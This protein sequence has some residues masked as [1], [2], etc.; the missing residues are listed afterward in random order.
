MTAR[1]WGLLI[2]L[3]FLWGGA[4]FFA[5]VALKEV[6]HHGL[7]FF[8]VVIAAIALGL[9]AM[10][11][12]LPFP[13]DW[14]FWRWVAVLAIFSTATPFTLLYWAQTHIASGL[15]AVLNAMTPIF[16]LLVAHFFT[17]DEKIDGQRFAGVL[18]GVGGV[19]TIVGPAALSG[20][21]DQ[22]LLAE[23]AVLGAALCYAIASVFGR[24]FSGQSP[25]TLS[26]AQM[27]VASVI[28]LPVM[29]LSGAPLRVDTPSLATVGAVIGV[30][31]LST[32][33]AFVLFFHIVARAGATNAILVTL[34]VPVSAI[35]LGVLAL[36]ETLG[37]RQLAGLMLIALG[38]IINDG[39]P[40][41]ALR[42]RISHLR[43]RPDVSGRAAPHMLN[44]PHHSK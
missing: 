37:L 41:A 1:E 34:L 7:A 44:E 18:A 16:T 29:L 10:L 36:G 15:A 5:A 30:G 43:Q 9:T 3:S 19:V 42:T 39:R 31:L 11:M 33:L 32:A 20:G 4:F 6:T 13:R 21:L 35:L 26:F 28:L 22:N 38:L 2:L 25:V 12:R 23:I 17:R 14:A 8:R 24:R 40:L 27:V